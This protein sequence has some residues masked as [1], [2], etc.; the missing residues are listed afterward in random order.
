MSL[1]PNTLELAS[2]FASLLSPSRAWF[3]GR[4]PFVPSQS[5]GTPPE[6]VLPRASCHRW[7]SYLGCPSPVEPQDDCSPRQQK[8]HPADP[9]QLTESRANEALTNLSKRC[10]DRYRCCRQ[11]QVKMNGWFLVPILSRWAD[12]N[13]LFRHEWVGRSQAELTRGS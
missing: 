5:R 10:P 12:N 1:P 13:K 8:N 11:N 4:E 9:S 6:G 2:G 7:M 3:S